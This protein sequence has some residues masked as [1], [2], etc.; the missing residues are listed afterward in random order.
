MNLVTVLE[1]DEG[2]WIVCENALSE[3][4]DQQSIMLQGVNHDDDDEEWVTVPNM[5]AEDDK[6]QAI[7]ASM[8]TRIV[9]VEF[10]LPFYAS[11][12]E[13][14]ENESAKNIN[15]IVESLFDMERA[16]K[17][18]GSVYGSVK[19]GMNRLGRLF[20]KRRRTE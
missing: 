20:Y 15:D 12:E 3:L 1:D 18:L 6:G 5:L 11:D 19:K 9:R 4:P 10:E 14:S 2:S 13:E 8:S 17:R 16:K 7:Y